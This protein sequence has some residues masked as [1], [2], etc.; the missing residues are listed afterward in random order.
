[1]RST[2]GLGFG[3]VASQEPDRWLGSQELVTGDE[4]VDEREEL[5]GLES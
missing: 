1:M 4:G 3:H 5:I 2:N